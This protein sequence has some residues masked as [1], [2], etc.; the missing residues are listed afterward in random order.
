M[1]S[2]PGIFSAHLRANKGAIFQMLS[3]GVISGALLL[4]RRGVYD[5]MHT[6]EIA[7]YGGLRQANAVVRRP[8][9]CCSRCNVRPA[10]AN[11]RLV[12]RDPDHRP[13]YRAST[14]TVIIC[15]TGVILSASNADRSNRRV[16]FGEI[17]TRR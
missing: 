1:G 14:W 16:I 4:W 10:P 9:S 2:S 15:R 13:A 6:R 12:R 3:H 8:C 7:F 17:T 11:K 5:R